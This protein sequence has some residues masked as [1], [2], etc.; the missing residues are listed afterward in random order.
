MNTGKALL[1]AFVAAV[2]LTG[3]TLAQISW[4][5]T[6]D[7]PVQL[8]ETVAE[9]QRKFADPDVSWQATADGNVQAIFYDI[10]TKCE[11]ALAYLGVVRPFTSTLHLVP[12]TLTEGRTCIDP[13]D[14]LFASTV[15]TVAEGDIVNADTGDTS[16]RIWL[17]FEGSE[18]KCIRVWTVPELPN[19]IPAT[20]ILVDIH[21]DAINPEGYILEDN[22]G[23]Q[24]YTEQ[25]IED[26]R[27]MPL[28]TYTVYVGGD[29]TGCRLAN[30]P[31]GLPSTG[32]PKPLFTLD[33]PWLAAD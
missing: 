19:A 6:K 25:P 7:K 11:E 31:T 20:G 3:V 21:V 15:I 30:L 33:L 29:G 9:G 24:F 28:T 16:G 32:Q 8:G 22:E 13:D 17:N 23:A 27:Y 26:I 4:E 1:A 14:F 10:D 5:V 18:P 2:V 12:V